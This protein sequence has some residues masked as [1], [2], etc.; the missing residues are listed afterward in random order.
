MNETPMKSRRAKDHK[1]KGE[2]GGSEN[3]PRVGK[4]SQRMNLFGVQAGKSYRD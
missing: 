1:R 3:K 4:N 2:A